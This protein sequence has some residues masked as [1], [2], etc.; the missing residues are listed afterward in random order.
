M[1]IFFL[2]LGLS[3][4]IFHCWLL[5]KYQ[6]EKNEGDL[7][8]FEAKFRIFGTLFEDFKDDCA[9]KQSFFWI[10][11]FRCIVL[12][13]IIML[14]QPPYMQAVLLMLTNLIFLGYFIY[15][16][17]FKSLFDEIS[18][19]FC[20]LTV[21]AAYLCVLILSILDA[22]DIEKSG[23]RHSLGKCIVIAGIV[24]A[25]GG[26]I[27]QMIQTIGAIIAICKF[28]SSYYKKGT[29]VSVLENAS[30]VSENSTILKNAGLKNLND[31]LELV[32]NSNRNKRIPLKKLKF[33][34]P[35][36][37]EI[38]NINHD[39]IRDQ[40]DKFSRKVGHRVDLPKKE[41]ESKEM[42]VDQ[43]RLLVWTRP[44][45][46]RLHRETPDIGLTQINNNSVRRRKIK[47]NAILPNLSSV[48]DE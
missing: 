18:Q 1:G 23:F 21:F 38:S 34:T 16:R 10:L 28:F 2:L 44:M 14:L 17:P 3:L 6:K 39:D 9:A 19:Y 29:Q 35:N 20:E 24:L 37:L 27:I 22:R 11:I 42:I 48:D 7:E 32:S 13:L 5:G 15:Y 31:H 41:E 43:P 36:D 30:Q 8:K 33:P 12:V 4:V 46:S 40:K 25:L 47:R 45:G 26:F